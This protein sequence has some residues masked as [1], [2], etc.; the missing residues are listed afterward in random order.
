MPLRCRPKNLRHAA[1]VGRSDLAV[2]HE[3]TAE[4][5]Q[6]EEDRAELSAALIAVAGQQPDAAAAVGDDGE[7]MTIVLHLI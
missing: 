5:R 6:I 3:L 4:P 2:E 1:R 7:S